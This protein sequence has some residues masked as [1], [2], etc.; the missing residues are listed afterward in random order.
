M[1]YEQDDLFDQRA[2]D[3]LAEGHEAAQAA[4]GAADDEWRKGAVY[5]ID[6]MAELGLVFTT[7]DVMDVLASSNLR[8]KDN[9]ALGGVVRRAITSKA[10][11]EV[12]VTR[13]RR[14]HGARI[15]VYQ[16]AAHVS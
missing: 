13:S 8:T 5:V 16:G 1:D 10:I 2:Q 11:V 14:R 4:E 3:A 15:P 12:G 6:K 9:R 7:D